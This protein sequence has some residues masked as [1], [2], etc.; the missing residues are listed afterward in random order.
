MSEDTE[1][2]QWCV[3]SG[4]SKHMTYDSRDL[5]EYKKFKFPLDVR[6]ADKR[7]V[8]ALGFGKVNIYLTEENGRN[9]PMRL[10]KV[11]FV[12]EL[13]KRLLSISQ[14]IERGAE[15]TFKERSCILQFQGRRF[16]FGERVG[17]L[18]ELGIQ[19]NL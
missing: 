14:V 18:F 17:N 7:I 4:C 8:K 10:E 11:L 13:K 9:V 3:D 16:R 12:P 15:I 5:V 19:R 2:N 6:L 1:D